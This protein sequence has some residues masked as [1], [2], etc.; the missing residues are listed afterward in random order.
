[1]ERGH[2]EGRQSAG[3]MQKPQE[4]LTLAEKLRQ[5]P[6][7]T[8]AW[9]LAIR[10]FKDTTSWRSDTLLL[11]A[12]V[13]SANPLA[14]LLGPVVTKNKGSMLRYDSGFEKKVTSS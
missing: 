7:E 3:L 2:V 9:Y 5:S 10:S 11:C 12:A 6:L 14:G 1:M 8:A 4:Q 13:S